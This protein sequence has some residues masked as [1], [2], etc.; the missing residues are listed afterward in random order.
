M[1]FSFGSASR[2]GDGG[3]FTRTLFGVRRMKM[4]IALSPFKASSGP[5]PETSG[6]HEPGMNM[7]FL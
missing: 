2:N 4:G 1:R 7:G 6:R 5:P 3:P